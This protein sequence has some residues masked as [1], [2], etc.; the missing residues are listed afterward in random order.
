MFSDQGKEV[1]DSL[2]KILNNCESD[3]DLNKVLDSVTQTNLLANVF[4][5]VLEKVSNKDKKVIIDGGERQTAKKSKSK[6]KSKSKKTLYELDV[7][8][9]SCKKP[10]KFILSEEEILH[11]KH[12]CLYCKKADSFKGI[13]LEDLKKYE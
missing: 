8:C 2:V 4:T 10:Q 11:K 5:S 13:K 9:E 3:E 12:K 7:C 6:S 1:R